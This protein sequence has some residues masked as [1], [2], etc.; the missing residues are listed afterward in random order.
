M[1][2]GMAKT[3]PAPLPL[4]A[5]LPPPEAA[6]SVG[7]ARGAASAS[8]NPEP[9]KEQASP[10]V[11]VVGN[12]GLGALRLVSIGMIRCPGMGDSESRP[13]CAPS[14]DAAGGGEAQYR[15]TGGTV[16]VDPLRSS[17]RK[18]PKKQTG[19]AHKTQAGSAGRE[20]GT[21]CAATGARL[22]PG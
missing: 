13:H 4:P 10:A 21:R 7:A 12:S 16:A 5:P 6:L 22:G 2:L 3:P 9:L 14:P 20:A 8:L 18:P 1:G 15:A 17:H 19:S 11:T